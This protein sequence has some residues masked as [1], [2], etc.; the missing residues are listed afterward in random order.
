[1][2]YIMDMKRLFVALLAL[3]V[4]VVVAPDVLAQ[5]NNSG[6]SDGSTALS[7]AT[8]LYC[9]TK[10]I[11]QGYI[12]FLIGFALVALG[13]WAL[14]QGKG[15]ASGL[16]LIVFGTLVTAIPSV[17][18]TTMGGLATLLT[19]AGISNSGAGLSKVSC[20]SGVPTPQID[21]SMFESSDGLAV[22]KEFGQQLKKEGN[23]QPP[24]PYAAYE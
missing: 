8:Y 23:Y 10:N 17:I 19:Q 15:I 14:I 13:L 20:G 12:G 4:M 6:V 3:V 11:L 7:M 16:I 24:P 5:S 1:M 18:E 21:N 9:G 2:T 22:T